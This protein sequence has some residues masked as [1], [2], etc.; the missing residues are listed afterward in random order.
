M[1]VMF[2]L[3]VHE[4]R[5]DDN[6]S[7]DPLSDHAIGQIQGWLNECRHG[8]AACRVTA[9]ARSPTRLV[10]VGSETEKTEPR[11]ILAG[12]RELTHAILSYCWGTLPVSDSS[13]TTKDNA[14]ERLN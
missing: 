5:S 10:D 11:L 9:M 14:V 8:H 4:M 13:K 6:P 12:Q 7:R 1:H 2:W 3:I